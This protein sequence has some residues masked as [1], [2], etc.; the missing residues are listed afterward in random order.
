MSSHVVKSR[1]CGRPT[2]EVQPELPVWLFLFLDDIRWV[3]LDPV[4]LLNRQRGIYFPNPIY[5]NIL[6]IIVL[7]HN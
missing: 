2:W 7:L 5:G 6:D 4:L 1:S 3:D